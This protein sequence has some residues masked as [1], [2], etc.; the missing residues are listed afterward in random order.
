MRSL[1]VFSTAVTALSVLVF[2]QAGWSRDFGNKTTTMW[3][4]FVEWS[5]DNVMYSGNPFDI[6][7]TVRFTHEDGNTNHIMMTNN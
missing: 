1:K 4:P 2:V 5:I 7:A 6:I 3:Y